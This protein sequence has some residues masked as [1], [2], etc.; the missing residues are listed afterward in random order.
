M[1]MRCRVCFAFTEVDPHLEWCDF[2][3]FSETNDPLEFHSQSRMTS[4]PH[5]MYEEL[6]A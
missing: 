3:V 5:P 4:E 1:R 2:N 6:P